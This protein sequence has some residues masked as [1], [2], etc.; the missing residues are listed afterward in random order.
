M[1][2]KLDILSGGL[3]GRSFVFDQP[4]IW[5]GRDPGCHV[6]FDVQRDDSVGRNHACIR[7][8]GGNGW[9]VENIH[10]NG[11]L[12]NGKSVEGIQSLTSG[13]VLRLAPDGPELRVS[14][15]PSQ[16]AAGLDRSPENVLVS[17]LPE[18]AGESVTPTG[19]RWSGSAPQWFALVVA[20]VML[21][22]AL[23]FVGDRILSARMPEVLQPAIIT[24]VPPG[25]TRPAIGATGQDTGSVAQAAA[26]ERDKIP[27]SVPDYRGVVWVGGAYRDEVIPL[28][29][30]WAIA[31]NVV[32]SSGW[33]LSYLKK[34][35]PDWKPVVFAGEQDEGELTAIQE[36]RLPAK[37]DLSLQPEAYQQFNVGIAILETS[38]P[39]HY[40]SAPP[41]EL[42]LNAL[43]QGL[44]IVGFDVPM[45]DGDKP[46]PQPYTKSTAPSLVQTSVGVKRTRSSHAAARLY[47]L[48]EVSCTT[49]ESM[50]GS[51]VFNQAGRVI[52]TW[53][54]FGYIVPTD[55]VTPLLNDERSPRD[56]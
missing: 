15:A 8:V 18:S 21:A 53:I 17:R 28:A 2:L 14:V 9:C 35:E 56:Q 19:S 51:P 37:F 6:P 10:A 7:S 49:P 22:V 30:G 42:K 12:L 27:A 3:R 38:L 44:T 33:I 26:A 32:V 24:P 1:T 25:A 4:E 50:Q 36:I 5:L 11:T 13:D 54:E 39:T 31:P 55:R 45:T 40:P 46:R 43:Q 16:P 52:G 29:S 23:L 20:I 48:W 47:P 34:N 41:A